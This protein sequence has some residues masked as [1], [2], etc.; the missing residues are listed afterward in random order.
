MTGENS[1]F[2]DLPTI[3]EGIEDETNDG[4]SPREERV[5]TSPQTDEPK[6][7]LS[8]THQEHLSWAN[9]IHPERTT[10]PVLPYK[11]FKMEDSDPLVIPSL[12]LDVEHVIAPQQSK[13]IDVN[14]TILKTLILPLRFASIPA[15]PAASPFDTLSTVDVD[16]EKTTD[17]NHHHFTTSIT[18][19]QND[20]LQT[21]IIDRLLKI[22]GSPPRR[23][24][25][26]YPND[27]DDD[28]CWL[29][30]H[31]KS[32]GFRKQARCDIFTPESGAIF[33][34]K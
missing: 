24:E 12:S 33:R 10:L 9:L 22:L 18:A 23:E 6:R 17:L 15:S 19:G 3:V 1:K 11:H 27:D 31:A 29:S 30:H 20:Q 28:Q 16:M 4:S 32:L 2:R 14:N 8:R 21:N 5:Q 25:G 26:Q 7:S 34:A 13:P